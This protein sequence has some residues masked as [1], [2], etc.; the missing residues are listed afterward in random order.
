MSAL[1]TYD[2]ARAAI[3]QASA[4]HQIVPLLDEFEIAKVRAKQIKDQA[5]LAD[6][7]EFQMRAERRLGEVLQLAKREGFF[8]QG[9]QKKSGDPTLSRPTLE[10]AGIDKYLSQRAQGRAS[11]AQQ[12]FEVMV[13]A[14][15]E[16]IAA[17]R[18]K[19]IDEAPINGARSVMSSRHEPD[20]SLDYFPT[21]P[22][23]TRALLRHVLPAISVDQTRRQT[24]WEPAC[25]EGHMAE[26]LRE[27]FKAVHASDVHDYGYQD[28]L[29]D[30]LQGEAPKDNYDWIVTNPPFSE[31][32]EQFALR[33]LREAK[34]GVALFVRLQWLETIGRYERLF[35][36]QP[37]T[38]LAF[39]CE[40]VN[41]CKARWEP[42][43]TTATAYIWIVWKHGHQR[44]P[45]LWIP[46]GCRESLTLEDDRERFT[47]HPVI[48]HNSNAADHSPS[49]SPDRPVRSSAIATGGDHEPVRL[50]PQTVRAGSPLSEDETTDI[51][52]FLMRVS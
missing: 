17:G 50:S 23:A 28:E 20:D 26:V 33:A 7:T 8:R 49:P 45:P 15:R 12:A 13:A 9:R 27:H 18:A 38:L 35:K 25:G 44:L 36:D 43:G 16:R 46:P 40:R 4:V 41:L 51:P 3:A 6:A 52:A 34:K 39:F 5:L 29:L 22:W 1:T 10:E 31:R 37:P 30:F 11:I 42:D 47:A 14:T 21:P 48:K 19:I 24:C 32:T 2:I